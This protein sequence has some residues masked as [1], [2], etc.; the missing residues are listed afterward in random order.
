M[1]N[2]DELNEFEIQ[3]RKLGISTDT[4]STRDYPKAEIVGYD[5]WHRTYNLKCVV[6][7]NLYTRRK[8]DNRTLPFCLICENK[9]S[10]IKQRKRTAYIQKLHDIQVRN[11][12]IDEY[13]NALAGR[14]SWAMHNDEIES[15]R[16]L[17]YDTANELK[18]SEDDG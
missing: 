3:C 18:G 10:L 1:N 11:V 14:L 17:I 5:H 7:G 12:A 6:C 15:V 2:N 13:A 9:L 4:Y 16:C 8:I